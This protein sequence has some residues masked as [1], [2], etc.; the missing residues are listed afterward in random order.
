M[1]DFINTVDIVDDDVLMDSLITRSISGSFND[2]KIINIKNNAF[3]YCTNLESVDCPNVTKIGGGAFAYCTNIESVSFPNVTTIGAGAFKGSGLK[4]VTPETFP[5]VTRI[6]Y[7]YQDYLFKDSAIETVEWPSIVAIRDGPFQNCVSLRSISFP[8]YVDNGGYLGSFSAK[9]CPSL[10][11]VNLPAAAISFSN[12]N[13][14]N[15]TALEKITLHSAPEVGYQAFHGCTSLKVID[16][17]S[18]TNIGNGSAFYGCPLDA[19]ILRSTTMCTLSSG[20]TGNAGYSFNNTGIQR[21][22]GHIYVPRDLVDSY[23]VATNWSASAAQFRPLEYYT[24]DGTTIGAM[25]EHCE[26]ISLNATKLTFT[27]ANGQTLIATGELSIY[28]KIT[29]ATSDKTVVRVNRQGVVTPVSDGTATITV[30]CGEHT[31]TC[32]VTVNAGLTYSG[33]NILD[34]VSFNA[35]Y[36]EDNGTVVSG[37][38]LVYTDKFDI[39]NYVGKSIELQL[40]D[41]NEDS[42]KNRICYYNATGA[43][44][45]Y[46][47]TSSPVNYGAVITS[48]VPNGAAYAAVSINMNRGFTSI[49]IFS[50][51]ILIGYI[52]YMPE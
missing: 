9:N 10:V 42:S 44:I 15:C 7:V 6:E 2:D 40:I 8:N 46:T 16:L 1:S 28:D 34:G 49:N 26:S 38:N 36:L 21:G 48:T 29:W 19:L 35:G 32:T 45:G 25:R 12:S 27:D 52:D 5:L 17:P 23:K 18:C 51:G 14:Q 20:A 50:D 39:S 11:D 33:I 3:S 13:F 37:S 47:K 41:V 31:A 22:T 43:N 24:I 4:A 30:M